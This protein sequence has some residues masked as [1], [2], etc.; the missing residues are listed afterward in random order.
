M[1]PEAAKSPSRSPKCCKPTQWR[2]LNHKGILAEKHHPNKQQSWT[3]RK[4]TTTKSPGHAGVL[5]A[6]GNMPTQKPPACTR[7]AGTPL[8]FK[9]RVLKASTKNPGLIPLTP[10]HGHSNR[11]VEPQTKTTATWRAS[12]KRAQNRL[13]PHLE[14]RTPRSAA[15]AQQEEHPDLIEPTAAKEPSAPKAPPPPQV[16]QANIVK[17]ETLDLHNRSKRSIGT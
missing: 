17:R 7:L 6:K 5:Q 3:P 2:Q 16:L 14:P 9:V 4:R 1:K 15:S 8:L 11:K 13:T 12:A 10:P